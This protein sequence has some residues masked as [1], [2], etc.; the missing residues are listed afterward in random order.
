VG[1]LACEAMRLPSSIQTIAR[2][3][4]LLAAVSAGAACT[5]AGG[6][7]MVDVPK[8]L[9]YQPPDIDDITGI[10]SSEEAE[11]PAPATSPAQNPQK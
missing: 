8:L 2:V 9:P 5:H 4:S 11:A 3:A 7:L 1:V 10:D 6:K